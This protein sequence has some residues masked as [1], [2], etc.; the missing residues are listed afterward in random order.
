MRLIVEEVHK[1]CHVHGIHIP[2]QSFDG[3]C[4]GLVTRTNDGCPLT[5]LQL[6]KDVWKEAE[7]KKK[8]ENIAF[9]KQMNKDVKCSVQF[10]A[11]NDMAIGRKVIELFNDD[12][13]LPRNPAN[14][15]QYNFKKKKKESMKS[16]LSTLADVILDPVK[17]L[18]NIDDSVLALTSISEGLEM[19]VFASNMPASNMPAEEWASELETCH[20]DSLED[21]GH[22]LLN[23]NKEEKKLE[24]KYVL[25]EN[26]KNSNRKPSFGY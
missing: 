11:Q 6:Q 12:I 22:I 16:T 4:H 3:Q 25:K 18:H 24:A 9:F 20:G 15:M 10:S 13:R 2:C 17:E 26:H 19:T 14:N 23:E 1:K 21:T 7:Q 8:N 5:I